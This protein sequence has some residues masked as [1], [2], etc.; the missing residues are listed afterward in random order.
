MEEEPGF[1]TLQTN[2]WRG[3]ARQRRDM[4]KKGKEVGSNEEKAKMR[5]AK[6]RAKEKKQIFYKERRK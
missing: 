1:R 4:K 2:R 3:G 5:T 6:K